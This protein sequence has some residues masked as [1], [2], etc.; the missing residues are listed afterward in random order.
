[1]LLSKI[2]MRQMELDQGQIYF[3]L[4][5]PFFFSTTILPESFT[6]SYSRLDFSTIE[7]HKRYFHAHL[8]D[9]NE[10]YEIN[11]IKLVPIRIMTT[12]TEIKKIYYF[13]NR[14][15]LKFSK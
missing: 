3:N 1:M 2:E 4:D 10:T 6:F 14:T 5:F 8:K 12:L 7:K 11:G 9:K 13:T 15:L